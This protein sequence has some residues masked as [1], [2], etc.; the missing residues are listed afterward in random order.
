MPATPPFQRLALAGL[1]VCVLAACD[2]TNPPTP[3]E[4]PALLAAA[5]SSDHAVTVTWGPVAAEAKEVQIERADGSGSFALR[6]TLAPPATTY[7]DASLSAS[8]TYRYRARACNDGGCSAYAGPVSVS[9]FATLSITTTALPDAVRGQPYGAGLN[10]TG[11][12]SVYTWFVDA[13]SLPAG[14]TM[15]N[16]GI[17]SGT[18]TTEQVARFT[19]RVRSGDG[20]TASHDFSLTVVA[21]T[22]APTL[23]VHN[24]VLPPALSN[25]LYQPQLSTE[26]GDGTAVAWTIV[27]G[28]LPSGVTMS[29]SGAFTGRATAVGTYPITVRASSASGRAATR[30]FSIVVV[31]DDTGRFNITRL[32][33]SAV[34][35]D[36][37]PHV[38]AAVTRWEAVIRGDLSR[39]D[40]PRGYLGAQQCAGF[41]DVTNGTSV[42]DVIILV[43]IAPIDG[44]GKI[45]GQAS[46]CL[47]RDNILT[48]VGVLTLDVEDLAVYAG[49]QTLTDILFHEI[50]HILGFGTLW[51]GFDCPPSQGFTA[52]W[53]YL[54][55]AGGAD[56]RFSGPRAVAEWQ[57]LGGTGTVPVENTGGS[58]TA[59]GHWRETIFGN[60]IMTGFVS[61]LGATNPLSRVTIASMEDLG[62]GVDYAA[63]DAFTITATAG[64]RMSP[65]AATPWEEVGR[66]PIVQKGRDGRRRTLP[67]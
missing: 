34:P 62:Y 3:P 55:G 9:T 5:P 11:A 31:A 22:T 32:D 30:T 26:G 6:T 28:S 4:P 18:P 12:D 7:V 14:L 25:Q 21:P 64:I 29:S 42:D 36:I 35:S 54:N 53:S 15:T 58:G 57:A 39:D 66:E 24:V 45:L 17:I 2:A 59:D 16:V 27:S 61:A 23:A 40:I 46:P 56:P 65:D 1:G 50:G 33:V 41:G 49:S 63:A 48:E 20:Q 60:E 67:R 51:A 52:C 38:A 44:R 43:N 10:A 13:G 8:T 37:S 19:A 47:I